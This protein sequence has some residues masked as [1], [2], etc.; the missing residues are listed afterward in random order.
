[1]IFNHLSAL[2]LTLCVLLA[3]AALRIRARGTLG[4]FGLEETLPLRALLALL[5]VLGHLDN[6]TGG[7]VPWLKWIHWSTPAVAGFFFLSGYGLWK[8]LARAA[9]AGRQADH[10]RGFAV[11]SLVR[12]VLP[13]LVLAAAW[14]TYR[15]L[16]GRPMHVGLLDRIRGG[17]GVLIPHDWFVFAILFLYAA[18][19]VAFRHLAAR[20]A[21]AAV[22]LATLCFWGTT[23]FAFGWR[24]YW[25]VTCC[26][27]P[28][29]MLFARCERTVRERVCAH[30][31]ASCL[32]LAGALA[33]THLLYQ[34]GRLPVVGY[35]R[36][37]FYMLLGPCV[38]L[39]LW[40]GTG[41]V[42]VPGL[43]FLGQISYE[44]FLVHGLFQLAFARCG[45]PP[46]VYM[47]AVLVATLAV[48][49]PLARFDALAL[50]WVKGAPP[51]RG[52][53]AAFLMRLVHSLGTG[54]FAAKVRRHLFRLAP[55]RRALAGWPWGPVEPKKVVF[56]TFAETCGC[57]PKYIARALAARCPEADLVWLLGASEYRR[58][59]G[60]VETGRAVAM[61]TLRAY[62]EVATAHVWVDNAQTF[63]LDGM[64]P[65]RAVQFYLDTWHGSL[66]I[67]RLDTASAEIRRRAARM[68]VV[69]AVLSNSD[70]DDAVFGASYFPDTAKPRT[71]HPR[72]DVFFL[73]PS[74]RRE[75]RR[76]VKAALGVPDDV[77]LAL[78][79]P[80]FREHAFAA[81]AGGLDFAAWA[82][83]LADRFGGTWRVAVRLH[84]H[85]AKAMADGL[86]TLPETVLDASSYG[87][88]QELLVAVE[89]GVTDY[90]SWIFD[91][92]LGGAPGFIYAPDKAAYDAAR[93][94]YY[95][96]EETPFPIATD[97]A[98][99][100]ANLRA[101]DAAAYATATAAFLRARGCM[102]DG[103]ASERAADLIADVL[104]GRRRG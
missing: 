81:S 95:P 93:G 35:V 4:G 90:S 99:L 25:Y 47:A 29:G 83:A 79:A 37:P 52:G 7:A 18:F 67:K 31:L 6:S 16:A 84:P 73:P 100:V 64:P 5:V 27:F 104:E 62:R 80:T 22:V 54:L 28:V 36:E 49:V 51:V 33:G 43:K 101:F 13:V 12:L 97:E 10:W 39:A 71:G 45:W 94:F 60:R 19:G 57:N 88:M 14:W 85:D 96:L 102:E 24:M 75:I 66:G 26:S 53:K 65:K 82:R 46:A 74:D 30:P 38:A 70:F 50:R 2:T 86:F 42:R 20:R 61:W 92:L 76:R 11:R 55:V 1:M 48:A 89:A 98:G 59:G 3:A 103:H 34:A 17:H 15:G 8:S 56:A 9:E 77:R 23:R 63:L 69:D 40:G 58:C 78:Y 44:V 91:F 21:C 68:S 72:N 32:I 41:P 87:D